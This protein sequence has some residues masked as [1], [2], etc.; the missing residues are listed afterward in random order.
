MTAHRT[1]LPTSKSFSLWNLNIEPALMDMFS[2]HKPLSDSDKHMSVGPHAET[3]IIFHIY[4]KIGNNF[5]HEK[6]RNWIQ[7]IWRLERFHLPCEAMTFKRTPAVWKWKREETGAG[8]AGIWY[9]SANVILLFSSHFSTYGWF[10]FR[11]EK[12]LL[13]FGDKKSGHKNLLSIFFMI[14]LPF[15]TVW[16]WMK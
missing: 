14:G 8:K 1:S 3:V 10:R 13:F 6:S 7:V 12:W 4:K 9:L 5:T 2:I 15:S 11:F 16:L